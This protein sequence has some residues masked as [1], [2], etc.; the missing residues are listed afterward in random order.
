MANELSPWLRELGASIQVPQEVLEAMDL[1]REKFVCTS[2]NTQ[3]ITAAA[4]P[5]GCGQT[6][7]QPAT[8]AKM[9]AA[10]LKCHPSK[11]LEIG[12]GSG[13]QTAVLCRMVDQVYTVE[14]I[15]NIQFDSIRRLYK[16]GIYNFKALCAD[17]SEG[18][19]THAPYDAIMVTAA[20]AEIPQSL[21]EQLK[22]NGIMVIPVGTTRQELCVYTKISD[23]NL[24]KESLGPINF[25]PLICGEV[26]H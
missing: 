17:G 23:T 20:A 3:I 19:K 1:P 11:V 8:V 6:I 25:V 12:T 4:L 24:R 18:W 9:T 15:Q 10:L 21:V 2:F 16:L 26:K 5:I 13:Y 22:I 14:R 7:S